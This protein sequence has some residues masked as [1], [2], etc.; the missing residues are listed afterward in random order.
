[1]FITAIAGWI[2]SLFLALQKP[3]T[4]GSALESYIIAHDPQTACDVD[5]LTREFDIKQKGSFL[6]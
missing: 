4:Y 3:Q 2:K 5:R 1:M 6:C